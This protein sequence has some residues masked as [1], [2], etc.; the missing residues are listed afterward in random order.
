MGFGKGIA[1]G[2]G[3]AFIVACVLGWASAYF[4]YSAYSEYREEV[5]KAYV[6]THSPEYEAV[7]DGLKGLEA[8]ANKTAMYLQIVGLPPILAEKLCGFLTKVSEYRATLEKVR[9]ATE[10]VSARKIYDTISF[11]QT[12]ST[13]SGI[14]GVILVVTGSALEVRE[15]KK[16]KIESKSNTM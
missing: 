8:F 13:T 7:I 5:E 14:V 1:V 9:T 11:M 2:L 3:I 6:L 16:R 4:V 10:E 12:V 15:R